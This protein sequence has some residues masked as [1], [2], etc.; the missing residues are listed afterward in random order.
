MRY[1]T[2]VVATTDPQT[3]AFSTSGQLAHVYTVHG[4]QINKLRTLRWLYYKKTRQTSVDMAFHRTEFRCDSSYTFQRGLSPKWNTLEE[5]RQ[6]VRFP[7]FQ[8]QKTTHYNLHVTPATATSLNRI[9]AN[10]KAQRRGQ[11]NCFCNQVS[12]NGTPQN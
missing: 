6:L 2:R 10:G 11:T 7:P 5:K 8:P 4:R 12:S 3:R 9:Y 1:C